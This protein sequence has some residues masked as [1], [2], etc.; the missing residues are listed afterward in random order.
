MAI[1][2]DFETRSE[3]DLKECGAYV[4]SAHPTTE[5]I[6]CA[7]RVGDFK[8]LKTAP[9]QFWSPLLNKGS[10]DELVE[11]LQNENLVI[12]HNANFE[13]LII[14]HVLGIDLPISKFRCTAAAAAS[15]ALPRKLEEAC[16]AL[17]LP[18][19]KDMAG[20]RLMLKYTKPRRDQTKGKWHDDYGELLRIGE[21]CKSDI[22]AETHLLYSIPNLSKEETETYH[23]DQKINDYGFL[24]DQELVSQILE[25]LGAE[26][27]VLSSEFKSLTGGLDATRRDAFLKWLQGSGLEIPNLRKETVSEFLKR[28]DLS[29]KIKRV[30]ELRQHLSKT[31][32]A[33]YIAFKNRAS[34]DNRVRGSLIYHAA[35]TGRFGGSGVQPQNFFRPT[36][37]DDELIPD[38]KRGYKWLKMI[39]EK[40]M[41]CFASALRA[42]IIAPDGHELVGADFNAIEMRVLFWM[43]QDKAGL[44][45]LRLKQDL[46][47]Q[48]AAKIFSKPVSEI[49]NEERHLGKT[50]VLGAGYGLGPTKFHASVTAQG[51]EITKRLAEKSISSY[52]DLH[53]G[54]PEFWRATEMAA[55]KAVATYLNKKPQV[56]KA[57]LVSFFCEKKFL[58]AE[59]PSG[60]RLAYYNPVLKIEKT[61]W[62]D[63]AAKLYHHGVNPLTKKWEQAGSFGGRLVENLVQAASRDLMVDAMKRIDKAGYKVILS[64]HDELIAEQT[65]GKPV[66][67]FVQL[68]EMVPDW[69]MGLPIKAEGWVGG[70]YRK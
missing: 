28:D 69:A 2:L 4:Y 51:I 14:K 1:L 50:I 32:T 67:E 40:P 23:L 66:S 7:W 25:M 20:R 34:S 41:E 36:V 47:K 45:A 49:T 24:T 16:I 58:W 21:Y 9:I 57:G 13:R 38:L 15:L 46:Y 39:R 22:E 3:C 70:R 35:S 18:V 12:A 54:V 19:K 53:S 52:R 43:A 27:K 26:L 44:I 68:M 48:M 42:M 6:C 63:D 62:G 5:I 64:V 31:S 65:K 30:L 8:T 10:K 60:R 37:K 29:F 55:K 17:D 59:L 56:F 11:A 61:P 33:K